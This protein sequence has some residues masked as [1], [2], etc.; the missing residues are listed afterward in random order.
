MTATP[1]GATTLFVCVTC[2]TQT[3]DEAT[4][5]EQPRAG[6]RLL[7]AIHAASAERPDGLSIMPVECLSNCNRS[8]TVAVSAPG[9]WTYVI[10]GLDPDAH[11]SDALAFARLHQAHTAG[12][13]AWRERPEYIRKNTIARVPPLPARLT[14]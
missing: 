4:S 3:I 12:L 13:P 9:K 2:R 10:G 11:A 5:G 14:A 1:P 7:A 6:E 8:C